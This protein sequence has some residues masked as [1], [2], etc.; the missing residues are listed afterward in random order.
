LS[1]THESGGSLS[2]RVG[3]EVSVYT[4]LHDPETSDAR[5]SNVLRRDDVGVLRTPT[6]EPLLH[7]GVTGRFELHVR[8]RELHDVLG[9]FRAAD[10][11]RGARAENAPA[12]HLVAR[13]PDDALNNQDEP[14]PGAAHRLVERC[15][16]VA[17][18][19]AV[20]D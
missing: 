1:D 15:G 4:G 8:S 5:L 19:A 9:V 2:E 18:V 16:R 10:D 13:D 6:A 11:D 7:I 20:G 3:A 14:V 17:G 12:A